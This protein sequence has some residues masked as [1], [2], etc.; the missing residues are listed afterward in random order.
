MVQ[1]EEDEESVELSEEI[2]KLKL[3]KVEL[4]RVQ[5]NQVRRY[6]RSSWCVAAL[7]KHSGAKL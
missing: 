3:R 2:A 5:N 1:E 4:E 6:I 7:R